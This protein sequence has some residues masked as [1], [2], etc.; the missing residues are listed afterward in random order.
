MKLAWIFLTRYAISHSGA[1]SPDDTEDEG[2]AL[3]QLKGGG[4]EDSDPLP[5]VVTDEV[6]DLYGEGL[7]GKTYYEVDRLFDAQQEFK[8]SGVVGLVELDDDEFD[9]FTEEEGG[10]RRLRWCV[11]SR[12]KRR[13]TAWS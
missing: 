12:C 4:E 6:D 7:E 2:P 8:E 3:L 9:D 11:S 5:P 10:T 13:T 1:G